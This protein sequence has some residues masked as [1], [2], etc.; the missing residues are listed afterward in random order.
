MTLNWYDI[1]DQLGHFQGPIW[2]ILDCC[3]AAQAARDLERVVPVNVELLAACCMGRKTPLASYH[4][5][6]SALMRLLKKGLQGEDSSLTVNQIFDALVSRK[7][8]LADTPF[9]ESL[10][11]QPETITLRRLVS[12]K[13]KLV[14]P[15]AQS[16]VHLSLL[17]DKRMDDSLLQEIVTFLKDGAPRAICGVECSRIVNFVEAANEYIHPS[18]QRGTTSMGFDNLKESP[19]SR[20]MFAWSECTSWIYDLV[21]FLKASPQWD[22]TSH[23]T[24]VQASRRETFIMKQLEEAM[25][26]LEQT[27]GLAVL[28]TGVASKE[29]AFRMAKD[30]PSL[31]RLG[32]LE[33]LRVRLAQ[34]ELSE[35]SIE[36]EGSPIAPSNTNSSH[37]SPNIVL[38]QNSQK[39]VVVEYKTYGESLRL[40][41][42]A[43]EIQTQR[44][45]TLVAI[46]QAGTSRGFLSLK[47]LTWS[48]DKDNFRYSLSFELPFPQASRPYSLR[49]LLSD[50]A[51]RAGLK[52]RFAIATKVGR[53]LLNWHI[54][55]W[56]HQGIASHNIVFFRIPETSRIDFSSPTLCGFE[57]ARK[58]DEISLSRTVFD[59]SLDIYRHPTRQGFPTASQNIKHDLYSFG[60][61]LLDVGLWQKTEELFKG[62]DRPSPAA[63]KERIVKNLHRLDFY[64]GP[65]YTK[66][67]GKCIKEEWG[68]G[69]G[70]LEIADEFKAEV[71]DKIVHSGSNL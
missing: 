35:P 3:Y 6:T 18:M 44:V 70:H 39:S 58:V 36:V 24:S 19:K 33:L 15:K 14:V 46:L 21:G 59:F 26:S 10:G 69:K 34:T 67:V 31:E 13:T 61:L 37:Y 32:V 25:T 65:E 40:D 8:E 22:T 20:V 43:Q 12:S 55:N 62:P 17:L 53:A 45:K 41:K 2:L 63:V 28:S 29:E 1:Q 57:F 60:V 50:K 27:L 51:N 4:S 16:S 5:F 48:H 38:E 54:A 11:S 64:M 52:N 30:Y 42:H 66:A 71:L 7:A 68:Q 47:C 23:T 56:L 9:R 49:E